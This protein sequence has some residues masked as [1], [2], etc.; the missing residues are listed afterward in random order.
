MK[1]RYYGLWSATRRSDLDHARTLLEA[2]PTPA[3]PAMPPV[4]NT[5]TVAAPQAQPVCPLCHTSRLTLVAILRPQ[6][7]VP[8]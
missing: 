8:P 4:T 1:V 7:K 5:P 6:R 2:E 3:T